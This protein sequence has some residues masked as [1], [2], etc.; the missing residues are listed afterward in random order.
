[1]CGRE[2]EI[3]PDHNDYEKYLENPKAVYICTLCTAKTLKEAKD[4]QLEPK[5][6]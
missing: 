3:E 2:V 1:M 6:M 4:A 5:P